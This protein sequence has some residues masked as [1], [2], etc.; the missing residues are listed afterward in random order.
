MIALVAT[1][2]PAAAQVMSPGPLAQAHASLDSDDDCHRCHES[3]KRVVAR[4][5]LDCHKDLG[6]AVTAGRGLHGTQYRGKPCEDC[7]V[8]HLGRGAKLIR[9]PGGAMAKLDHAQTGWPLEGGHTRPAC[10]DCHKK[11]SALGKPQFVATSPACGSCHGDPHKDRFGS[12][13]ARCHGVRDWRSFDRKAFDHKLARYALTG[14]HAAVAC[15]GCHPGSPPRWKPLE[16]STCDSCHGDPHRGQ[17]KPRACTSCHD[18]GGWAVAAE[19]MRQSHPGLSLAG[20]HA[21]VPCAECHDQGNRKPPSKGSKCESCH[22][23]VHVAKFGNRCESCHAAIRWVGLPEAIGR[24]SHAR[25]RYPLTGRHAGVGCADCHPRSKPLAARYRNLAFGTCTS[26]HADQHEAAFKDQR[27]GDCAQCHTVAGFLPTTFGIAAHASAFA[28]SGKHVAVPCGGCHAGPRPRLRF[29]VGKTACA[30]CHTNPHGA[31]FATEMSRGGCAVCHTTVDWRQSKIDHATWPLIGAHAR[32]RCAACHGERE[33]G[34]TPAAYRGVPRD[35]EGCHD[36]SHAGQFR[37]A[38]PRKTC[39][40]C[41]DATSF[42]IA[43]TFDHATTG[44]PLDG[45]HAPLACNRCHA[46]TTLRDGSTA[47]RWR[48]G[49]RRCKDCHANPHE[50]RP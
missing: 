17:F 49:Y 35:C 15:E 50:D 25:T 19:T 39:D 38:P 6:A 31:Q 12:D 24:D 18:T 46:A 3:G 2:A 26:C 22:R 11:R 23:P 28:L 30:E 44:Y 40:S 10:L 4:L 29:A 7:H 36:D 16:F 5:C 9:W 45:Q 43:S 32:T 42:A 8:E 27:G 1:A 47:I 13:C 14:R 21:R 41:H 37:T 48:L 33:R 20:G 34:A